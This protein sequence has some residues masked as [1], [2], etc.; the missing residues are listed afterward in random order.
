M[1]L[2]EEELQ[3]ILSFVFMQHQQFHMTRSNIAANVRVI[4][5]IHYLQVATEYG[6]GE[7]SIGEKR[8]VIKV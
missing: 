2:S 3:C 6:M 4:E 1:Y 5:L 8:S 7:N